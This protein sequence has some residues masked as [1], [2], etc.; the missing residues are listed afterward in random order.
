MKKKGKTCACWEGGLGA[1]ASQC[2]KV[3]FQRVFL[4]GGVR[5][6]AAWLEVRPVMCIPRSSTGCSGP[7][8]EA[9]SLQAS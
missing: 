3:K 2:W 8:V 9:G 1:G 5:G 7:A 6:P 4:T